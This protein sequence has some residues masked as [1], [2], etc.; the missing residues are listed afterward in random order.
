MRTRPARSRPLPVVGWREWLALPGFGVKAIKAKIDTGARSSAIHA[1][2]LE[3]VERG[4]TSYASFEVHPRQR[5]AR[6][7]VRVEAEI[8]D[9][10]WVRSSTGHR[11]KRYVVLMEIELMGAT[12]VAEVTLARRDQ[13]GFRM[14]LGREALRG[15]FL[16]DPAASYLGGRPAPRRRRSTG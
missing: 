5:S 11:Q 8:V 7:A 2:D 12:W 9:E 16:V 10:R 14:L 3:V 4:G 6:D 13:M 15:R 1:F